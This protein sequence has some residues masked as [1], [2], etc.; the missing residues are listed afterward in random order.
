VLPVEGSK[1][2][3]MALISPKWLAI[4][5][6]D[7]KHVTEEERRNQKTRSE[8]TPT[9]YKAFRKKVVRQTAK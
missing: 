9:M 5:N 7:E 2:K 4:R 1:D 8:P 6:N 3:S